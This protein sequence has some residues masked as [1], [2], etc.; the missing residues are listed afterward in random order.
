MS[1]SFAIAEIMNLWFQILGIMCMEPWGS[2][3]SAKNPFA[4]VVGAARFRDKVRV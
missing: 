3:T 4:P 1:G 2:Q